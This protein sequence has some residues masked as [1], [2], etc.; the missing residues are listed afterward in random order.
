METFPMWN[1]ARLQRKFLF[2]GLLAVLPLL[3]GCLPVIT[4]YKNPMAVRF[5]S[6]HNTNYVSEKMIVA[7][8]EYGLGEL[9][10]PEGPGTAHLCQKQSF[11]LETAREIGVGG[12]WI[13]TNKYYRAG[14]KLAKIKNLPNPKDSGEVNNWDFLPVP[15]TNLWVATDWIPNIMLKDKDQNPWDKDVDLKVYLFDP[16]KVIH[17]KELTVFVPEHYNDG[18]PDFRIDPLFQHI[19]Y[20]TRHGY[21]TYSFF[22]NTIVPCESPSGEPVLPS[23]NRGEGFDA[24]LLLFYHGRHYLYHERQDD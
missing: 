11:Y 17:Q 18:Y 10:T 4:T 19:T 12:Y 2:V 8:T 23:K 13:G 22:D 3:S 7:N 24:P 14:I 15:E 6:Y 5:V 21:E 9:L 16:E 1:P 20:K